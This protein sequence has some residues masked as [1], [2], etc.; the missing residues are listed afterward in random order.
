M[1]YEF[2]KQR[3]KEKKKWVSV[4]VSR[5]YFHKEWTHFYVEIISHKKQ[6]VNRKIKKYLTTIKHCDNLIIENLI[7]RTRQRFYKLNI[8]YQCDIDSI[9]WKCRGGK[10]PLTL[11]R[12]NYTK[13]KFCIIEGT[14]N[15]KYILQYCFLRL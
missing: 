3:L 9:L 8:D 10:Y 15:G 1:W 12:C 5:P 4:G 14:E 11:T 13:R 6:K 2:K 7:S